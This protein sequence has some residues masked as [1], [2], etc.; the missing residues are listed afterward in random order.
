M[1]QALI[2]F[3][4]IFGTCISIVRVVPTALKLRRTGDVEGVSG[5]S[6]AIFVISGV[7]WVSYSVDLHNIPSLISS[8]AGLL[9]SVASLLMLLRMGGLHLWI[10]IGTV[11]AIALSLLLHGD[12]QLMGAMAALSAAAITLPQVITALRAPESMH[13][14]SVLSWLLVG[15]NAAV[16]LAYGLLIGDPL[17]GAAGIITIPGSLI[18][19]WKARGAGGAMAEAVV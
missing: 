15:V 5:G 1:H 19:T 14:V 6:L 11:V 16:W 17:L 4:A 7:W 3:L 8:A 18:I 10:A 13:G 2:H 9:V 12:T